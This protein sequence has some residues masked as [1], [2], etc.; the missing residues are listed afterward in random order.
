MEAVTIMDR[1]A[2]QVEQDQLYRQM[3]D[4]QAPD[5]VKETG[6]DALTLAARQV[7]ETLNASA[8]VTFT[9]TGSTTLRAARM[10]PGVPILCVTRDE[11]VARRMMMAYGASPPC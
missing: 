5:S 2:R 1:I 7:A 6:S 8:I 9:S 10:R 3:V 11:R 4:A